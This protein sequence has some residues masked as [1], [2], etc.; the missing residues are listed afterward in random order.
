MMQPMIVA[1]IYCVVLNV[2]LQYW[3]IILGMK[4]GVMASSLLLRSASR[5]H[6]HNNNMTF[7][8][9]SNPSFTDS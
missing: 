2:K 4:E 8:L 3:G 6:D 9:S 5:S 7:N 1:V